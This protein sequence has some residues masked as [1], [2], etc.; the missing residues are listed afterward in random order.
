VRILPVVNLKLGDL[1]RAMRPSAFC[2][3]AMYATVFLVRRY[4][5]LEQQGL[6]QLL[7]L[8]G[9]GIASYA[10]LSMAFNM[11]VCREIIELRNK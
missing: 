1:L 8:V 3:C 5:T 7:I 11:K 2:A 6:L 10:S 9:A 4:V